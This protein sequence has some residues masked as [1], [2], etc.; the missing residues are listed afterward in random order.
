MATT[1][2]SAA[3]IAPMT[4]VQLIIAITIG[5]IIFGDMPDLASLGGSALIVGAGLFLWRSATPKRA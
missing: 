5:A 1:R 4:Y 2:A 3:T